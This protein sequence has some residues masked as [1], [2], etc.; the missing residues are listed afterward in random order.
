MHD[1]VYEGMATERDRSLWFV[2]RRRILEAALETLDYQRTPGY[3]KL[4]PRS[5]N[6]H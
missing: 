1:G 6:T 4:V 3:W 2:G 5:E